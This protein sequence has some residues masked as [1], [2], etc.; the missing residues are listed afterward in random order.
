MPFKA[1][2]T[3][4]CA[5]TALLIWLGF[6]VGVHAQHVPTPEEYLGFEIGDDY[7]LATYQQALEYFRILDE[8]SPRMKLTDLGKTSMGRDM[9]CA[10]ISS[11]ENMERLDR[12]RGIS[13]R[14]AQAKGLN[15]ESARRLAEEGRAVVYIDGG[16]HASECAPAQHN[17]NLAYEML[18]S[19][20]P[21][22]R[23]IRDNVIL[24]LV[25]ANPDGMDMLAEWYHPNVGTPYETS[26]MPWLYH[27][28]AG[29]DNNRDS[30]MNNLL[31]TRHITR[32]TGREWHPQILFNQHQ[33]APF[34]ARIWVPPHADPF[35]PNMHPL[36]IRWQNLIGTAMGTRFDSEGKPGA[37]SRIGFD[38]WF[39]GYVTHSVDSRNMISIL[40]ET[41]LYRYATPHHYTVEDFPE[42]YRDLTLGAF[43]PS[44]WK[45]GW[46]RLKDAVDYCT[47]ASIAVLHTAAVYREKMLYDRYQMGR[48]VIARFRKE[49]PY[50]WIIPRKQRDPSSAVQLLE[51]MILMGVNVFET[52]APFRSDSVE[53]PAGT[54]VI[55]MDQAFGLFVK[56]LFEEQRFPDMTKY[57]ALWQG[58]SRPQKFSGAYLPPYDMAGWTLPYQM[59]VDVVGAQSPLN[60]ELAPVKEVDVAEGAIASGSGTFYVLGT[61]SNA[62]FT[63]V[64]RI[65]KQGGMVRRTRAPLELAGKTCEPGTFLISARSVK[66]AFMKSL[67]R[68]LNLRIEKTS[69]R[70]IGKAFSLKTPRVALYKSWTANM[71][72]GWT[73]FLLEKY[74]FPFTGVEDARI[75]AGALRDDFDVLIIPAMSSSAIIEGHKKGTVPP[76][77]AGGI[78]LAGV[79]NIKK[80]IDSGGM[81]VTLNSG[82]AFALE[83][84]ELPVRN[85]LE[86]LQ[87]PGRSG[88]ASPAEFVCPGSLL[89][90]KFDV[91]HP[92]AFGMPEEAAGL[93]SRSP[94]FTLLPAFQDEVGPD[95][96]ARYAK[97]DLLM[98]GYLKGEKYL[99]GK[100]AAVEVPLGAGKVILLGFGV[101]SRAQPHAT[102]KLLFN[103]LYYA[104]SKP[105]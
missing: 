41:A 9:I 90:M 42:A 98:S 54:W 17:F 44:P 56:N 75:R 22:V 12:Y 91:S 80:F 45:G 39:P 84:L 46:W 55:P 94:V 49:A 67:A 66:P 85:A 104:A 97:T 7:H 88:S 8:A 15:D 105:I 58:I 73:R 27:K 50:A 11:E 86:N 60:A 71:D 92:V 53:Y 74:E 30:F 29:H 79:R 1:K 18:T 16:L 19:E 102:F 89:K 59:G 26:P 3:V 24:L 62:D 64:N 93:F 40:T 25:F 61:K 65:L 101:Q 87:V 95:V 96:I 78:G 2:K 32:L 47:T 14:L 35:N 72:E 69:E 76:Q 13:G 99:T 77:Y 70:S 37:I 31:E 82:C 34:P 81:L 23:L 63:A 57:P 10:V 33:T 68:D 103:S 21:D 6:A 20:D 51:S 48:D 4:C 100:T 5:L 38:S 43:Y 52:S 28:Y 83:T 36:M